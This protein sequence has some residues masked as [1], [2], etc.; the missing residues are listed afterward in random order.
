MSVT[1]DDI[2][3][4]AVAIKKR[5]LIARLRD[6]QQACVD[7]GIPETASIYKEAADEI[8]ALRR[9]LSK[10]W[11]ALMQTHAA[12]MDWREVP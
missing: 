4:A 11:K 12:V 7:A 10:A 9:D 3:A 6:G 5:G 8:E 1:S 2:A